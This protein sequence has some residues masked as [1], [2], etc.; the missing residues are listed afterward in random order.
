MNNEILWIVLVLSTF[1][2]I[3]LSYKFFGKVGLYVWIGVAM[4]VCN[5]QVLKT[6]VLFG[7]V[8][9]LGN[10]LYG[11]T[12]LVTDILN[13]IYGKREAQKAVWIGFYLAIVTM[14]I[15]QICLKFIPDTSDFAQ[16]ALAT[17]FGLFPRIVLASL[18]AY[19]LS[20]FHDI[21][22]YQVWRKKF[23]KDS[24]IWIRNNASTMISQA[25]D[26]I[27]FCSIAFWG[28][29]PKDVFMSILVTTY[30]FKFVVA[31]ADTPFIY[32]AKWLFKQGKIPK[33]I[34]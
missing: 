24:Q 9:T 32:I 31:A 3:I 34:D 28:M 29:F 7:M 1:I 5:I 8:G 16:G 15:M 30:I 11:T 17:I 10:A 6:I 20:Q 4:I 27:V 26:S 12:F 21:W 25:I 33:G 23:P 19:V 18:T 2:G 22:A 13:E 14:V